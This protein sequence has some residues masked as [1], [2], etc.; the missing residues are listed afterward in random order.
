MV[1][2]TCFC[3]MGDRATRGT[4]SIEFVKG[5]STAS[6]SQQRFLLSLHPL[7]DEEPHSLPRI[8]PPLP[9]QSPGTLRSRVRNVS[10]RTK[11][12]EGVG[13]SRQRASVDSIANILILYFVAIAPSRLVAAAALICY[14]CFV[15][16]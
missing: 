14:F 4:G 16:R 6:P 8:P 3:H 11:D 2:V 13:H 7:I 5:S 12:R 9:V 1:R 10:I 15:L